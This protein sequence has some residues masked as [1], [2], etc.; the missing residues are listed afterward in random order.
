LYERERPVY[1]FIQLG[2][3]IERFDSAGLFCSTIER[4]DQAGLNFADKGRSNREE[5]VVRERMTTERTTGGE[6]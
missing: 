5:V 1:S 6:D 3:S 2:P 4:I